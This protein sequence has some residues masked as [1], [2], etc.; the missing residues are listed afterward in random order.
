MALKI[1]AGYSSC[2]P[3]EPGIITLCTP[4]IAATALISDFDLGRLA[5][6]LY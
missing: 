6:T 3:K 1:A 2:A 5:P 4:G